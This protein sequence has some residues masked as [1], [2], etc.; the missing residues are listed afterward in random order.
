M[1]FAD[2]GGD[3]GGTVGVITS[4]DSRLPIDRCGESYTVVVSDD[5]VEH[6]LDKATGM[7]IP[8]QMLG[9]EVCE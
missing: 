8:W 4:R 7:P 2:T 1:A 6:V 3:D 5:P 9:L